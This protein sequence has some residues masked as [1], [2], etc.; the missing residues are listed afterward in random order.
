MAD[1][2]SSIDLLPAH[3]REELNTLLRGRG[4]TQL[5]ATRRINALLAAEGIDERLS[6]SA[7]NRYAVKMKSVGER[8]QQSREVA[9]MWIGKLG[10]APQGKLGSLVNE[11][12]RTLA[13]DVSLAVQGGDIDLEN[14]PAIAGMLKDLAITQERLEKAASENQ[15]REKEIIAEATKT[16]E[17]SAKRAGASPE[18]I[19]IIRRDLLRMSE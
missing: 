19:E 18:T 10:T 7:V 6:K 12:L 9:E 15:R 13:F 3:I 8:L 5:E 17:Q 11:M 14:A 2:P 16:M 4:I 1:M